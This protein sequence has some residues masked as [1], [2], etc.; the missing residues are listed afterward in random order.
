VSA[1]R[2]RILIV[3]DHRLILIGLRTLLGKVSGF[4]VVGEAATALLAVS[5]ARLTRPDVVLMDV[6]LPDGS[7]IEACRDIRSDHPSV[8][9]LMLTSYDDQDAVLGSIMAGAAGY[10]LKHADPDRLI[11]AIRVV[12]SGGSLLDPLVTQ[13][14]LE[15]IRGQAVVAN[16]GD[17]RAILTEQER[18]ILPLIA[19]GKTNREI[20]ADLGLTEWTVKTYVSYVLQKLHLA[21]RAEI[22]AFATRLANEP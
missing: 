21:R 22:A 17:L 2:T 8:R 7:G 19:Q 9:V 20:G 16:Q 3:D 13:T 14:A 18:R 12:R 11:D 5:E 6:R 15:W 1:K 10:L 4:E